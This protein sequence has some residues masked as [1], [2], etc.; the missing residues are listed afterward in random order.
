MAKL[1]RNMRLCAKNQVSFVSLPWRSIE[2][3]NK[4]NDFRESFL[5]KLSHKPYN[6][7]SLF[8]SNYKNKLTAQ[9]IKEIYGKTFLYFLALNRQHNAAQSLQK[10]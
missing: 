3:H 6:F 5:T 10:H 9:K 1:F 8:D 7:I 2:K 4:I